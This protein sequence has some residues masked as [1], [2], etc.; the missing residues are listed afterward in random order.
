MSV[1]ILEQERT[2]LKKIS[3][4]IHDHPET[5]FQEFQAVATLQ[6]YLK[7]QGFSIREKT[8]GVD[9]AFMGYYASTNADESTPLFGFIGEYDAL[10][11]LGHGC[12]HNL[13]AVSALAALLAAREILEKS[14]VPF[15]IC[16]LGTP[17]EETLGGK[18]KMAAGGAFEGVSASLEAHPLHKTITDPGALS[19]VRCKVIFHGKAAHAA[20][21]PEKGINALDAVCDFVCKVRDWR[22]QLGERERVHGI[23]TKG[24]DAPN[25]IPDH[26]EAFY[27][28]RA[29]N[30]RDIAPLKKHLIELA[31]ASAKAAGCTC[32]I[33]WVSAYKGMVFN[34][35]LNEALLPVWKDLTGEELVMGNGTE[36]RG[37]SD[38][39]DVSY[40][41]PCAQYYFGVTGGN[42]CALHTAEFRDAAGTDIAFE[43]TLKI[44]MAMAEVCAKYFTDSAFRSKVHSDWKQELKRT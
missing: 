10:A 4:F 35:A 1:S 33:Q 19:V 44:G 40:L 2:A 18:V 30:E 22:P 28:V 25:I 12:G 23:I 32:E 41:M 11:G 8:G 6:K 43:Q 21:C 34:K 24:G 9:T 31:E 3:R 27:Y 13:I 14:G 7:G 29:A 16:Y 5:G 26:T 39:G 20:I 42:F 37:S 36:G 17:A 15:R 38:T